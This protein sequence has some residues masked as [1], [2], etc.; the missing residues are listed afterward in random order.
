LL[1][2]DP[3]AFDPAADCGNP[4]ATCDSTTVCWNDQNDATSYDF[5]TSTASD[6]SSACSVTSTSGTCMFNVAD[7]APG[8]IV[9]MAA[10]A[11]QPFDGSWGLT[12]EG[13][14][15]TVPCTP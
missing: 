6:F 7:P 8:E 14:E 9:F 13:V 3:M 4:A 5:A 11:E 12:S 10:G 2:C 15:R 1:A